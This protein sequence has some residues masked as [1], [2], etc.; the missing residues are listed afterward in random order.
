MNILLPGQPH[1]L[2]VS[3]SVCVRR[4]IH[5]EDRQELQALHA[6]WEAKVVENNAS[7][8][9]DLNPSLSYHSVYSENEGELLEGSKG[10]VLFLN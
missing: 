1:S 9:C 3:I 2:F 6:P 4:I 5:S 7:S 8:N 10:E